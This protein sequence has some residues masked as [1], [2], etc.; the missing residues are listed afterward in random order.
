MHDGS[1]EN[2]LIQDHHLIKKNQILC[3]T[4]LNSNELY[5]IQITIKHEKPT[6]Q[7]YFEK[8]FKNSNLD[9]KT[10]YLFPRITAVDKTIRVF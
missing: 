9:W 3:L 5:Q 10:I 1:L 4:K 2:L 6:S 8:I 7:S